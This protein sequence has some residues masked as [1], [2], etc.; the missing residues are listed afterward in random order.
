MFMYTYLICHY[1]VVFLERTNKDMIYS[2]LHTNSIDGI[3]I[4]CRG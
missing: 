2:S 1:Y 3:C 4:I